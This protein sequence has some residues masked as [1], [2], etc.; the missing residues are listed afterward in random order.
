LALI[1]STLSNLPTYYFSLFPIPVGVPNRIEK[2]HINFL[3]GGIG[4]KFKFHLV[5]LSIICT[6]MKSG[7]LGLRNLI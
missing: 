5:H 2:L 6:L 4:N 7:G 3:W 1:T